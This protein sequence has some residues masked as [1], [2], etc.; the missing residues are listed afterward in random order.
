MTVALNCGG[1]FLVIQRYFVFFSVLERSNLI[2]RAMYVSI[3]G[4]IIVS[5]KRSSWRIRNLVVVQ[6]ITHICFWLTFLYNRS[7]TTISNIRQLA[8]IFHAY[9]QFYITH[10]TIYLPKITSKLN[11]IT[12]KKKKMFT[13]QEKHRLIALSIHPHT[14]AHIPDRFSRRTIY[15]VAYQLRRILRFGYRRSRRLRRH[16]FPSRALYRIK[17]LCARCSSSR[18]DLRY[19]A[20][21]WRVGRRRFI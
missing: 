14:T 6:N 13:K 15:Y 18:N 8:F 4:W 7:S 5:F 20:I 1:I 3:F 11:D 21:V 10:F 19:S 17:D 2:L 12:Q 9:P 16:T